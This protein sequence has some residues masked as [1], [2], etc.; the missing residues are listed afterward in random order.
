VGRTNRYSQ[1]LLRFFR[2]S[3]CNPQKRIFEKQNINQLSSAVLEKAKQ[4]VRLH[5]A[6]FG[7]AELQRSVLNDE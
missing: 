1:S 5:P 4:S 2:R 3:L 6:Q 7:A